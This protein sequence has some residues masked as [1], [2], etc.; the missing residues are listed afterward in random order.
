MKPSEI[1][2]AARAIIEK[3]ENW[4]QGYFARN[5]SY[6]PVHTDSAHACKFCAVGALHCIECD[7]WRDAFDYA[8]RINP[9]IPL[10]D[11]NDTHTHA[12]VLAM[13]DEAIATAIA[14]GE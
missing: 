8:S 4:T 5:K 6:S 13:F 14:N 2:T 3:P 1:L 11:F 10:A 7:N 12:E 9:N